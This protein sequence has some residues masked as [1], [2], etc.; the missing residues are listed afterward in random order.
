MKHKHKKLHHNFYLVWIGIGM[1][2]LYWLL[3]S[4]IHVVVF[5]KGPFIKQ[6][7]YPDPH[8][9]WM[10]LLVIGIIIISTILAQFIAKKLTL[11][12]A[13]KLAHAEL[14]Q[15][16]N[17]AADGMRV[18]DK[19]FNVLR[20]NE[21]FLT[22]SGINKDETVSKKC[23]DVFHGLL[24]NAQGCPLTRILKGEERI[25]CEVEK[26]RIDGIKVTCIVTATPF[27]GPGGK[28]IGIVED[29][30]D[31]TERKRAEVEIKKAKNFSN[32]IVATVPDS[33]LVVDKDLKIKSANRTFYETFQTEPEKVINTS[34]A[35]FLGDE[36]GRLSA[37]LTR[38]FGTDDML[39]NFELPYQLEKLGSL[40]ETQR[41][42]SRG[43]RIFNITA[44]RI[45][46]AEEEEEEEEELIVLQDITERKRAE[47]T[48]RIS[49]E[50]YR[51]LVENINMGICRVTPGEKG[52]HIEINPAMSRIFGYSREELLRMNIS[53]MYQDP[54][55]RKMS[56][57]KVCA[58]GFL[59]NEYLKLRRKDGSPIIVSDTSTAVRDEKGN[60]IYFDAI[61]EDITERKRQELIQQV[62]Y[63]ISSAVHATKSIS[64]LSGVIQREL[65]T[66]I[67]TKNFFIA[68]YNKKDDTLSLP[69]YK[70]ET[71]HFESFPAGKTCTAYVIRNDQPL[72]ANRKKIDK[73]VKAGE[74]EIIG[75][76]SKV[77]LGVPLK[78]GKE[79]IGAVVIQSYT[80][81][82]AYGEKDLEI[83]K[84]IA[85]QLGLFIERKRAE[86][87]LRKRLEELEIFYD[88]TI[89][90]E[91]RIIE[92]KQKVNELLAQLG[93]EKKY[94][95]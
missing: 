46:I 51:G 7:L 60:I 8:E 83:L 18:I 29:F 19:D 56:S 73:L 65:G 61:L 5:H 80:D 55:D 20:V 21:T 32:N 36:D 39:E 11:A 15:I 74:V 93:K 4:L 66:I 37:A 38:L 27:C 75:T 52:R 82:N 87:D 10:R 22:L 2:A 94:D 54:S 17:T 92:L 78:L 69:Y 50:K 64:E 63:Q 49:E 70:D 34:I 95:V 16:F 77:W 89:G 28:L 44:R 23:Y 59:K 1:G 79:V 71:D 25:E 24:C 13:T 48:L 86:E 3:E 33:L 41:L 14:D 26:E 35:D 67:D 58:Q 31:I 30:K 90:R 6:L 91:G 47:E 84:Y 42:I 76:L 57:D 53:D 88:A 62:L 81:E 43:E 45:I 12:E 68:L 85:E 40:H 72:L 9:T